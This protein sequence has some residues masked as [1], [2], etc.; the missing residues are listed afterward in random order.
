MLET[1][2]WHDGQ[3]RW[4]D[5]RLLP[6]RLHVI[7]S[8]SLEELAQAIETLA[9]RGA[10]AIGIAAAFG[11]A[12]AAQ[13]AATNGTPMTGALAEA[14]V[15]LRRTRPT[16]VNLFWALDRM[17]RVAGAHG[18][19]MAANDLAARLLKEAE[20]ILAE[21]LETSRR[22]GTFGLALLKD[23]ARVLTHCNAGGLA[24]GG[25]GTALAPVY[26]AQAAGRK[27]EVFA[28]ETRPLLQ[29]ARL[30]AWE[31]ANADIPVTILCDGA[32]PGLLHSGRIDIVIVGAD[33]VARNG[34]TANKVGTFG[35][36]LAA[37][38][39]GVP[40]YV[41]APLSTF[42]PKIAA[43]RDIPIEERGGDEVTTTTAAGA[44]DGVR[45][46]NP[47][48]DVTPAALIAGWITERGIIHPPFEGD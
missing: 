43:G 3:V 34:D 45:V 31:M 12:L 47:A 13:Q 30:T 9:V 14:D 19:G 41:A 6:G 18:S 29:G 27:V 1:V 39:A 23:G 8:A 10:P 37:K 42:D 33:R 5:Q 17:T 22:I 25:L 16:A 20:L 4:I 44:P 38:S 21:D 48:F 35:A 26:A 32:A 15:R 24:T 2:R 7:T 11:I 40:F 46:Y 36:A 28:D